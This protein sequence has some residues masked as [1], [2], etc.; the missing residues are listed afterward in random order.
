MKTSG[1]IYT[2]GYGVDD[3]KDFL[4]SL[5]MYGI[6]M[7]IDVRSYPNSRAS[8]ANQRNL[9]SKLRNTYSWLPELAG[10]TAASGD[11]RKAGNGPPRP[12]FTKIPRDQ[13]PKTWW[14]P[15]LHAY[16]VWMGESKE[17]AEGIKKLQKLRDH[18]KHVAL[19]CSEPPWYKCHR[20]MISD[21]WVAMG[22]QVKHI[23]NNVLDDHPSGDL[24]ADRLARYE[25]RTSRL[26]TP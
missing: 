15:G 24:L 3:Y 21:A 6:K 26:W 18:W 13:R 22:G 16:D 25:P 2:I 23:I 9:S 1:I 11:K 20:S 19:M 17:F 7:L 4:L 8:W 10:P 5:K 12:L 14:S